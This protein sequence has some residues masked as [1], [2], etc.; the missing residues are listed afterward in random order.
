MGRGRKNKGDDEQKKMYPGG[1]K[2]SGSWGGPKGENGC[3]EVEEEGE[4]RIM[5][6]CVG[7][8]LR[9]GGDTNPTKGCGWE[10]DGG[11]RGGEGKLQGEKKKG[12]RVAEKRRV[13]E[14]FTQKKQNT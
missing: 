9:N 8:E 2:K 7:T 3:R 11:R 14:T 6:A 10:D 4:G 13:Y 5:E 1:K 12:G